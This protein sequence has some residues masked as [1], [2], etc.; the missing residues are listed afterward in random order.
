M[1]SRHY[2]L[3][4]LHALATFEA[5]ARHRSLTRAADELNVTTGAV[6]RQIKGLEDELGAALFERSAGG[7]I[8]TP[9]GERLF[10]VISGALRELGDTIG[11][12]RR[13]RQTQVTVACTHAVARCWLM[14]RMNRFWSDHPDICVNH[15]ISD[16]GRDYRRPEVD[17]C[18]RYGFGPWGQQTAL[19][20][21]GDV[22]YP[23]AAPAFAQR[24]LGA[25]KR[26]LPRM[27]LLHV[28]WVDPDWTGWDAFLRIGEVEHAGVTGRRFSNFD[29][30]LQA[31]KDGQ[32]VAIGWHSL[33]EPFVV[34]GAL[35]RFTDL[36]APAPG[37]YYLVSN[38]RTL[39]APAAAFRDWLVGEAETMAR[40]MPS[41]SEK[42]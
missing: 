33:V 21:F 7:L 1:T 25:A 41:Q 16:D 2:R 34:S 38:A 11:A 27:P 8:M 42:K 9:D 32:G 5:S 13:N 35:V 36:T 29:V 40:T 39:K 18:I 30:A 19:K 17:L 10:G 6:S 31:C 4:S 3:P 22:L 15:L 37:A 26:D 12:I 28:D 24:H 20:L 23:V 14:P